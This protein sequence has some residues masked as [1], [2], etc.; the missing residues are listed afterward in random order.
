MNLLLADE[1]VNGLLVFVIGLLVVFLGMTVIVLIVTLI[2]KVMQA[3][4]G[5]EKPKAE[6]VKTEPVKVET[7][8]KAKAEDEVDDKVKAAI[9]AAIAAYYFDMGSGCEF[10]VKR[11]KRI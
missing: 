1:L 10:K 9:F 8:A 6:E 3:T 2:G 5:K 11:I 7:P 4:T